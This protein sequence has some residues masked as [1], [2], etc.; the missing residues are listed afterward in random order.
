M[1]KVEQICA[2]LEIVGVEPAREK[3]YLKAFEQKGVRVCGANDMGRG[4]RE[5]IGVTSAGAAS[6]RPYGDFIFF[7]IQ[8]ICDCC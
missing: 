6:G 3:Q 7:L 2:K 1:S 5:G 4:E 8:P